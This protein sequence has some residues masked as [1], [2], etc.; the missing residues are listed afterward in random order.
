MAG[1]MCS[2]A[3]CAQTT[4]IYAR[5]DYDFE[6]SFGTDEVAF[7]RVQSVFER[8]EKNAQ[9]FLQAF[10]KRYPY[11][12]YASEVHYMLAVLQVEKGKNKK[13]LQEFELGHENEISRPHQ[14][15]WLFYKGYAHLKMGETARAGSC[16]KKLRDRPSEFQLQATY[17]AAYC[18]Y[19]QGKYDK[20]LTDF[21]KLENTEQYKSIVPYYIIQIYYSQHKYGEVYERAEKLLSNDPGNANSAEIHRILGEIYYKEGDY[22]NAVAHLNRYESLAKENMRELVREDIYILG[23][24][25]YQ[26]RD[27]EKA[28]TYLRSLK[29][30]DD[31][32]TQ[33][34]QYHLGL[35]YV[36]QNQLE[37]AQRAFQ[38]AMRYDF[39]T[40]VQEE[41]HF[42]YALTTYQRSTALGEGVNAFTSF[43]DKWPKSEHREMVYSLLCDAFLSSK[44]YAAALEA[45]SQI[46][47]P[48]KK[49]QE[50]KQVLRY[51][52]GTDA[53]LQGKMPEAVRA[54]TEVI[55]NK[56]TS[57]YTTDSYYWRAEAY[58]RL[59]EFDSTLADLARY[60]QQPEVSRNLNYASAL[61]LKGYAQFNKK[62][63]KA[64][65]Q[66]FISYVGKADKTQ[67]TYA[68][69]LNRLGD[70]YFNARDFVT[71]E[72]YYAKVIALHGSGADYA[73][74]QRG[75][76][77][78]LLR[79][80]GE[81][82]SVMNDLVTQFPKSD[83]ADD[84]L[85]E[86]ARA[87]LQRDD[88]KAAID[89]YTRLLTSYP[90]SVMARKAALEKAMI[91]YNMHSYTEAITAYKDVIAKYPSTDE[92]Y[93]A[94]E[95]MEACYVETNHIQEYLAY[96][97]TLGKMNMTTST[98]EDSLTYAAAERQYMQGNY[99]ECI[100]GLRQYTTAYCEGGRYCTQA[101]YFLADAYYRT[102]D[103]ANAL[104]SYQVLA[105]MQG[106][107]YMEEAVTR[108]AEIA[109]DMPDYQIAL[110]YFR[111][112]QQIASSTSLERS[113][114]LGVLRCSY[115]LGDHRSTIEIASD[116]ISDAT[117]DAETLQ[118]A[119]YNRAKAYL[120]DKRYD[121]AILDLTVLASEVR[122]AQGAEAKYLCAE[123]YYKLGNMENAENEIMSFAQM[124]TAQQY[125]LAR[126]FVLLADINVQRGDD[127]QAKQ[128]LLSLQA[129]YKATDDIQPMIEERLGAIAARENPVKED[130]ED[131]D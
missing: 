68:D 99:A 6:Q 24:A 1:L 88:N 11:T 78:G 57:K 62:Q 10:L 43:L 106:N 126:A 58:Y 61:Y 54:L 76:A 49:M 101:Y 104:R 12:P 80:Y 130:D 5:G 123:A 113:A 33:N 9:K 119:R 20:A 96:T 28:A 59:A 116:L 93:A 102:G 31:S 64:A 83:Y 89:A 79:R 69:A 65:Q 39:S 107:P 55:D 94:L 17:Y 97:K 21:L 115:Y 108:V 53:F 50:T 120:A 67:A 30:E 4:Q 72:S 42:N 92:A 131:E 103:K 8:R 70:T 37:P 117:I 112:L 18:Q 16:F 45:L 125:W 51:E 109:Y 66:S 128:Y 85:Y 90:N 34:A 15:T 118:E 124:N 114:R 35:C 40:K 105:D 2:S 111:R 87:E 26:T 3:L 81:K 25:A 48:T 19:E 13:A 86:M 14:D 60:E 127:F 52:L 29:A 23:M 110:Q 122:T 44:N 36:K 95:G 63:Y 74:F 84:A 46:E 47:K 38:T 100:S 75:Y 41:A 121:M 56:P 98:S 91:Y 82:V 71:A 27:F 77:M 32:L 129:N 22:A 7:K 73:T